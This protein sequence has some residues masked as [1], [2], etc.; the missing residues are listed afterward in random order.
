MTPCTL[1]ELASG[2]FAFTGQ[3][4]FCRVTP[5][6]EEDEALKQALLG[7]LNQTEGDVEAPAPKEPRSW[8]SLLGTAI[9]YVWPDDWWLQVAPASCLRLLQAV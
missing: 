8:V 9:V 1:H 6:P 4:T 2:S 7:N 3:A 5:A